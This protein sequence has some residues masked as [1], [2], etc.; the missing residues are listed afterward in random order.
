MRSLT[1]GGRQTGDIFNLMAW[2]LY[3]KGNFKDAVAAM[4]LAI[5]R[6]PSTVSNY[7]DLGMILLSRRSSRCDAG[8]PRQ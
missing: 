3:M 7:L 1:D 4:D 2:C 5:E 8:Y 6:E